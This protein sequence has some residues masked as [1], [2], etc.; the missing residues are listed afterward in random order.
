[1]IPTT[2]PFRKSFGGGQQQIRDVASREGIRPAS[3]KTKKV[4]HDSNKMG[5]IGKNDRSR[6][7]GG[8]IAGM[9]SQ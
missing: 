7:K 8:L 9:P 4:S 3:G 6:Q 1:M 2:L 5:S